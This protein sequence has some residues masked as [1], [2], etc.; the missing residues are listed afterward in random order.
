MYVEVDLDK[1]RFNFHKGLVINYSRYFGAAFDGPFKE[2]FNG[3]LLL[4]EEDRETFDIVYTW[5]NANILTQS[6][7]GE[8]VDCT[9]RQLID[10]FIFGD[11]YD[12]P[13]LQDHATDSLT[14]W[15]L[16]KQALVPH[17]AHAYKNA[18]EESPLRRILVAMFTFLPQSFA[19]IAKDDRSTFCE[20][21]E[22][23]M[24]VVVE[25]TK[26]A[27]WSAPF[28]QKHC[29]FTIILGKTLFAR[30]LRSRG[31]STTSISWRSA[32]TGT[33]LFNAQI[34]LIFIS[35]SYSRACL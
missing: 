1:Q 22:F 25:L 15:F 16:N 26:Q 3:V 8:D 31:L 19:W 12:M 21:P 30:I 9:S 28:I 13:E 5:L 32:K 17:F 33:G 35:V 24:D 20:C 6:L 23:V 4:P 29:N 2:A 34:L 18:T 27:F 11:R 14:V 10:V 7:D